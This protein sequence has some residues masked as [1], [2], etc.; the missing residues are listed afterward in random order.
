MNVLVNNEIK[1]TQVDERVARYFKEKLTFDNPE[2]H[3]KKSMGRW[4]GNT[5]REITLYQRRGSSIIIPFGMLPIIF[6]NQDK[7]DGISHEFDFER[8]RLD[9][10]S[11]INLYSYQEKAA[12]EALRA[13]QGIVV[14]PC[15]SGKTQIGLEIAARIGGRTLWLTHTG[16]LLKQSMER[17]KLNFGLDARDYGTI[18][19]GKV[20]IGN[21]ITFATVQTMTKLDLN[22][23]RN[24]WD[25]VIVD[26]CHHCV[27]TPTQVMMFYKVISNLSAR[28][29]FGL[30]ATP[31]RADGLTPCMYALIGPKICEIDRESVKETTCPVKVVVKKTNYIPDLDRILLP[32]G[33]LSWPRFVDD[34]MRSKDRNDLIISDICNAEG[35][36]LVLTDRIKHIECLKKKLEEQGVS[37]ITLSAANSKKE[38]EM[39]ENSILLLTSGAAKVMI[40]TYQLA[41]EGLDVPNLN[42]IFLATPQKNESLVTQAAGRVARKADGKDHGTVFDYQDDFP[43]LVSWQNKRNRIYKKL[44]F[45]IN[46]AK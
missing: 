32:N 18:T 41:K 29:K 27:G 42:N 2:Y 1:I 36:S 16:D 25:V 43:M 26:E 31:K 19:A 6:A 9:Y 38:K 5:P 37:V 24:C 14:A 4:L 20:D 44:G 39:R 22:Q 33:T 13:R 23:Y 34:V 15:G 40:A 8:K 17:A 46:E 7:W 3:K 12:T 10:K 45:E 28:Y 35:T 11:G 21:V 30:T